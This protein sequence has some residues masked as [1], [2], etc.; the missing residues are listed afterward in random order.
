MMNFYMLTEKNER[1][2]TQQYAGIYLK[3]ETH[4]RLWENNVKAKNQRILFSIGTGFCDFAFLL[5]VLSLSIVPCRTYMLNCALY[6][7]C[8]SAK[9]IHFEK[10]NVF[11]VLNS[12]VV[13]SAPHSRPFITLISLLY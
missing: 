8:L 10:K 11:S 7:V 5:A 3:K 9:L 13:H 12:Q 4:S 2:K 6:F 1:I